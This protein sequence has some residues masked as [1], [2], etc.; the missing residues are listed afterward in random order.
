MT[1]LGWMALAI[2]FAFAC[3][4]AFAST[5][6]LAGGMARRRTAPRPSR[7]DDPMAASRHGL[8]AWM[9]LDLAQPI[10]NLQRLATELASEVAES[11]QAP[12]QSPG[13]VPRDATIDAARADRAQRVL[14]LRDEA[15]RAAAL[16]RDLAEVARPGAPDADDPP[17]PPAR[18][19]VASR[20]P[21]DSAP[22]F[23]ILYAEAPTAGGR[24]VHTA[25][26]L[27]GAGSPDRQPSGDCLHERAG[28]CQCA[29]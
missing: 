11:P 26:P 20:R 2:A 17:L 18:R 27:P 24:P 5:V 4:G 14:R 13:A 1:E 23:E 9:A 25:S 28:G 21:A 7:A 19:G 22:V 16:V 8:V 29:R 6:S 10:E 12:S 15:D 3:G